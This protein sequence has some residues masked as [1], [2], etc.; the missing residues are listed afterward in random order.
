MY[1]FNHPVRKNIW[2]FSIEYFYGWKN[3]FENVHIVVNTVLTKF[4]GKLVVLKGWGNV[5]E[6]LKFRVILKFIMPYKPFYFTWSQWL[7]PEPLHWKLCKL[8]GGILS[9]IITEMSVTKFKIYDQKI[10]RTPKRPCVKMTSSDENSLKAFHFFS[11]FNA[12]ALNN[13][14]PTGLWVQFSV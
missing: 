3:S 14:S 6:A 11:K 13:E 4:A 9:K 10:N 5:Q 7:C 12:F 8:R 2:G 1:P